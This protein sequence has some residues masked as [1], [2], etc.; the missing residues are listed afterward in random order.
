MTDT[1]KPDEVKPEGGPPKEVPSEQPTQ[2]LP[3]QEAGQAPPASQGGSPYAPSGQPPGQPMPGQQPP[4]QYQQHGQPPTG[5]YPPPGQPQPGQYSQPGQAPAGQYAPQGQM[6]Q[7]QSGPAGYGAPGAPGQPP[8]GQPPMGGQPPAGPPAGKKKLPG[9][10]IALIIV[11]ALVVIGGIVLAIVFLGGG[12]KGPAGMSPEIAAEL[13]ENP[14]LRSLYDGCAAGDMAACDDLYLES[15]LGSALEEFGNTCG[16][17]ESGAGW[18]DPNTP[19][20]MMDDMEEEISFEDLDDLEDF[21]SEDFDFDFDSD[22]D[23]TFDTAAINAELAESPELRPLYEA[24]KSGDMEA[25]DDLYMETP[26][27]SELEEFGNRCGGAP[28]DGMWCDPSNN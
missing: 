26:F 14:E 21:D 19:M 7:P 4:G 18:C 16:G 15:P 5:Q 23:A 2:Q 20:R 1:N 28:R 6:A 17:T 10:G 3:A 12:S 24:C 9:W 11:G 22:D 13:E 8:Y 27:G 25:C